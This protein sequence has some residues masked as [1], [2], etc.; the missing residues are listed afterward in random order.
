M[1]A[2]VALAGFGA[3]GIPAARADGPGVGTPTVVSV[4][5]S[6]ISGEAGRWA[7][8]ASAQRH[9]ARQREHEGVHAAQSPDDARGRGRDQR[10]HDPRG[11]EPDQQ[12]GC[13]GGQLRR[14]GGRRHE[15]ADRRAERQPVRR[16]RVGVDAHAF[17]EPSQLESEDVVLPHSIVVANCAISGTKFGDVNGNGVRD[18]GEPGLANW[19][20]YVDLNHN[21][22]RDAGEPF[23]DT[24]ASGNYLIANVP[25][26]TQTVRE[27]GIVSGATVIPLAQTGYTCTAP[28]P[29][30]YTVQVTGGVV[31]ATT[32][33]T[34]GRRP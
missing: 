20:M 17:L 31:G 21:G 2:A 22:V 12:C 6:Y 30:S 16:L 13:D 5:D 4:G 25:N 8:N 15:G 14:A 11:P 26:G 23:A 7:G 1:G 24:D 32:S 9:A 10:Q 29:C 3:I 34:T 19:R 28:S 18:P 27:E 33:A